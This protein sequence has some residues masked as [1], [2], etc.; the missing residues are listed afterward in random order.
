VN[1]NQVEPPDEKYTASPK[2]S[3]L[4]PPDHFSGISGGT[5]RALQATPADQSVNMDSIETF[6]KKMM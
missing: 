4:Q 1:E 6:Q 2:V 3:K 5:L